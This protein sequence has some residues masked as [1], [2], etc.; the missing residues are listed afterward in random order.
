MDNR[1]G[2]PSHWGQFVSGWARSHT[3]GLGGS[4]RLEAFV[5]DDSLVLKPMDE[6]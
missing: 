2:Q 3:P 6:D 1:P 4:L 5:E